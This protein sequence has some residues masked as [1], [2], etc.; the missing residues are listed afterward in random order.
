MPV[1]TIGSGKHSRVLN[2]HPWPGA[3]VGQL[4]EGGG[5]QS[6]FVWQPRKVSMLH[7]PSKGPAAQ[8]ASFGASDGFGEQVASLH[9]FGAVG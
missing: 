4:P 1:R 6:A 8:K 2:E 9:W 7:R 5:A 3:Q